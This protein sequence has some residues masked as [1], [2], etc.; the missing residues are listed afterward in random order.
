MEETQMPWSETSPMKERIRFIADF[1][2]DLFSTCELCDRYHI[3]RKTGYKWLGRFEENGP[4]G[5][6]ERSRK[7]LHCPHK[8]PDHVEQEIIQARLRHPT[9]GA[10][11]LLILLQR[12]HLDWQWPAISTVCDIIKRNGLVKKSRRQPRQGH[13]GKPNTPMDRP[14]AVWTTDFKGEFKTLDGYYCYPLTVVDGFSRFLLGCQGLYSTSYEASKPVF[15][16]L[17][18]EFGL[19]NII[20]SDNGVPFA[21]TAI[22]R[23]SKLSVW[24]IRLGIFPELIEPAH[25]QQNGRHERMHRTL[26]EETTHPPA[27][28]QR[29]QQRKFNDFRYEYNHL[30]PHEAIGLKPPASLYVPS[31]RPYPKKLP[32]I[33]YPD[34]FEVRYVSGNGGI[35]WRSRWVNV[36]KTLFKQYVGLEEID[37]GL[38]SVYFGPIEL[39]RLDEKD[40]RIEDILGRKS[41]RKL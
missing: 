38:W 29:A 35:R 4:K 12:R 24:W 41:R 36:S 11:K 19:P 7:P 22:A 40:F 27:A 37:N 5:L 21:T 18:K 2:R 13:S 34:H 26:K 15:V 39:G 31:N 9:W 33:E 32:P 8:T 14:N 23:L 16:R 28:N 3:S 25:P 10:K 20:R 17:F 6:E 1:Q 30:R